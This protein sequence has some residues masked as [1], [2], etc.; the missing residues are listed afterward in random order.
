MVIVVWEHDY[1]HDKQAITRFLE[2]KIDML[3]QERGR[4]DLG[5]ERK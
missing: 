5:K 1:K 4:N 2:N 3:L